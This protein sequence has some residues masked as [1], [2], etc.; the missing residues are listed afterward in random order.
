MR[1]VDVQPQIVVTMYNIADH[2]YSW[3]LS[4]LGTLS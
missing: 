2:L 1:T 3:R 4:D